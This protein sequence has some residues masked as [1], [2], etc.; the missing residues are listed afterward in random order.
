MRFYKFSRYFLLILL[1]LMMFYDFMLH[2]ADAMG[3][4]YKIWGPAN[5]FPAGSFTWGSINYT[6]FWTSY[7]GLA[8]I[9]MF[10]LILII[11]L[12]DK[13]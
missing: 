11:I 7:W 12:E 8:T 5:L 6:L 9:I 2:S 3:W 10:V 4:S 1:S 13:Q